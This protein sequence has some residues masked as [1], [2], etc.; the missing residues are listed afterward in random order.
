MRQRPGQAGRWRCAAGAA[1]VSL[2][3]VSAA[4]ADEPALPADPDEAALALP[5]P[6]SLDLPGGAD[7]DSVPLPEPVLP[8]PA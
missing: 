7:P 4:S 2:L 5:A 8:W 3:L 6:A 1:V